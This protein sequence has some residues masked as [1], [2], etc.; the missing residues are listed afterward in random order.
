MDATKLFHLFS[1]YGNI[2]RI[3][4]LHNKPD[5]ALVQLADGLQAELAV[6][7][8][9]VGWRAAV[10]EVLGHECVEREA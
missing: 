4:F 1:N 3:K 10:A 6:L 5:H 8:V 7:F 2:I 9:K